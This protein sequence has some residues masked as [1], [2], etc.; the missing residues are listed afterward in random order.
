MVSV[1][2]PGQTQPIVLKADSVTA[3]MALAAVS[4]GAIVAGAVAIVGGATL[5]GLII[6]GVGAVAFAFILPPLLKQRKWHTPEFQFPHLPLMIG[7][8]VGMTYRLRPKNS[9]TAVPSA[10]VTL[11]VECVEEVKYRQ[12]SNTR[13]DR[14]TVYQRRYELNGGPGVDG[15][16]ATADLEI[17]IDAG[18]PTLNLS[19]NDITWRVEAKIDSKTMPGST[20]QVHVRVAPYL[21]TRSIEDR[22]SR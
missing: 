6:A 13:T 7:G 18:A 20:R 10:P 12:G 11:T 5:L 14:A 8:R 16:E 3:S 9:G 4:V 19:H 21:D 15:F 1:P 17:P 2:P 22:R